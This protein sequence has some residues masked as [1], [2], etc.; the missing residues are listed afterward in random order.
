MTH[1]GGIQ[2]AAQQCK[3]CTLIACY[4]AGNATICRQQLVNSHGLLQLCPR[5]ARHLYHA[6]STTHQ[7]EMTCTT[8]PLNNLDSQDSAN[9]LGGKMLT[10]PACCWLTGSWCT[11][12]LDGTARQEAAHAARK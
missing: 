6:G 11:Q 4:N 9:R 1:A 8:V 12:Q 3:P 5:L 2:L 7:L 10:L